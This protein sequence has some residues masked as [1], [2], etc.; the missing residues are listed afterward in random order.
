MELEVAIRYP[1]PRQLT[2]STVAERQR[3][4]PEPSDLSAKNATNWQH[5]WTKRV[6]ADEDNSVRYE[7]QMN[8][9]DLAPPTIMNWK[10][11]RPALMHRCRHTK[12]LHSL[13]K[14]STSWFS[15]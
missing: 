9:P 4:M 12:H 5:V 2:A 7:G 14:E 8:Y 13:P 15:Y 3:P 6:F 1:Q 11:Y 10:A